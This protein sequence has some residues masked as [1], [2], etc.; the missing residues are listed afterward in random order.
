EGIYVGKVTVRAS[1]SFNITT[2]IET[3][4]GIHHRFFKT[5]HKSDGY[6]YTK[7]EQA[8]LPQPS[9]RGICA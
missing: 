2:P 1:G 9:G 8:L 3:I 6:T 4:Q 7:G 5:I